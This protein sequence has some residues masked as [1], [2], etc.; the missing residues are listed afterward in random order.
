MT[1]SDMGE[2]SS[3]LD[4]LPFSACVFRE[5]DEDSPVGAKNSRQAPP[6]VP[7]N[8][9]GTTRAVVSAHLESKHNGFDGCASYLSSTAAHCRECGK[10]ATAM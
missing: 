5:V 8:V 6:D 1:Y 3:Q 9:T 4:S 10:R 2:I 7:E